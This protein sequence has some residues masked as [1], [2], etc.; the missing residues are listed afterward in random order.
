MSPPR[1]SSA[2]A[3]ST[4]IDAA[5]SPSFGNGPTSDRDDTSS[6]WNQP[7]SV[8]TAAKQPQEQRGHA[9]AQWQAPC[10]TGGL[11]VGRTSICWAVSR[12]MVWCLARR[13]MISGSPPSAF[14][15][16]SFSVW[17]EISPCVSCTAQQ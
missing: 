6:D 9:T 16:A 14:F 7:Y 10:N 17:S 2:I 5:S 8:S 1:W 4:G 12:S 13:A 15:M 11:K 3:S